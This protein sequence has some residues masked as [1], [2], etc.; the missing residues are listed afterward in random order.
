MNLNYSTSKSSQK[1]LVRKRSE[2][3]I[4][5]HQIVKQLKSKSTQQILLK[6][7]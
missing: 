5:I 7:K 4:I 1:G 3:K 6:P 2:R